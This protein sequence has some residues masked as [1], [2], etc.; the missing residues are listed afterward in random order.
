MGLKINGSK[1]GV[2]TTQPHPGKKDV[3]NAST[4]HLEEVQ[5]MGSAFTETA[6]MQNKMD[7]FTDSE[8]GAFTHLK[9]VPVSG[10][11]IRSRL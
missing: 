5:Y 1:T 11:Q 2:I 6:R 10:R 7:E 3:A 9:V 4:A 8:H